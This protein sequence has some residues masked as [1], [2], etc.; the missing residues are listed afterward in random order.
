MKINVGFDERNKISYHT[1]VGVTNNLPH[2]EDGWTIAHKDCEQP[3]DEAY[4]AVLYERVAIYPIGKDGEPDWDSAPTYRIGSNR[5]LAENEEIERVAFLAEETDKVRKFIAEGEDGAVFIISEEDAD[6]A[7]HNSGSDWR[8]WDEYNGDLPIGAQVSEEEA[9]KYREP[10][11]EL[12]ADE[13]REIEDI[14]DEL[15]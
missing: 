12:S 14:A 1:N 11:K 5:N 3:N 10:L 9:T 6:D 13:L 8:S 15:I 2:K 7:E 4:E